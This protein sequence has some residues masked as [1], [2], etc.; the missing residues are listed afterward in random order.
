MDKILRYIRICDDI[1]EVNCVLLRRKWRFINIAIYPNFDVRS[2]VNY[3]WARRTRRIRVWKYCAIFDFWPHIRS[4]LRF[5][6]EEADV[7]KPLG[8]KVSSLGFLVTVKEYLTLWTTFAIF[9]PQAGCRF[10][11]FPVCY[12][13]F[14]EEGNCFQTLSRADR[15]SVFYGI[16]FVRNCSRVVFRDI[17]GREKRNG[18]GSNLAKVNF[19]LV[20]NRFLKH[21]I[22]ILLIKLPIWAPR[23]SDIFSVYMKSFF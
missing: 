8:P 7:R 3:T 5:T 1:S 4:K 17:Q 22:R 15:Y 23:L 11:P 16:G 10:R 18:L 6:K 14:L 21:T 13:S 2:E 9:E 12:Q 19:L 20:E